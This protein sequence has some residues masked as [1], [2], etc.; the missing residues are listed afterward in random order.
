MGLVGGGGGGVGCVGCG[1]CSMSAFGELKRDGRKAWPALP[2]L[3]V[4]FFL[5]ISHVKR[6]RDGV[7]EMRGGGWCFLGQNRDV[8]HPILLQ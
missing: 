5:V 8:G 4:F 7:R 1:F 3:G 2:C 6:L